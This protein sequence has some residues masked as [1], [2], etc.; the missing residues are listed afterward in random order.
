[1]SMR[2]ASDY[3]QIPSWALEGMSFCYNSNLMTTDSTGALHPN[4]AVLNTELN[5]M[6]AAFQALS[7][8]AA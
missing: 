8:S 7:A 5:Q 6:L 4:S 2:E 3:A 1:M